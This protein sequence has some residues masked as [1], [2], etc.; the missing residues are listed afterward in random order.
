MMKLGPALP[1]IHLACCLRGTPGQCRGR[2]GRV[3][4]PI[5][6]PATGLA[7]FPRSAAQGR[8]S[9]SGL[10]SWLG[11]ADSTAVRLEEGSRTDLPRYRRLS[12]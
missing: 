7:Q 10:A 3:A 9:A 6:R 2:G 8:H 12:G 4:Q 11:S 5:A 1:A